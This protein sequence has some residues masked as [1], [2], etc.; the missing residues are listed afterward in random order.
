MFTVLLA[1][2]LPIFQ[3]V[4]LQTTTATFLIFSLATLARETIVNE[5]SV[6]LPMKPIV[7]KPESKVP[8]S[9]V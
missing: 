7:H 3:S 5:A 1:T 6:P 4:S 9:V 8:L 2:L